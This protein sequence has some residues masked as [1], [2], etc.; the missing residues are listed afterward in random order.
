MRSAKD[1]RA[2]GHEVHAA[3]DDELRF[4]A[5]RGGARELQRVADVV[6]ELDDLIALVM[7]PK[8]HDTIAERLL[9]GR[10]AGVHLVVGKAQVFLGER[11]TLA[12][13]RL[14]D[15]GEKLDVQVASFQLPVSSREF[16]ATTSASAA[17]TPAANR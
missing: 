1:V 8:D 9:G 17:R 14:F 10:N 16:P 13:A 6:G 4:A 15:V 3:E 11:L 12:D 7:M 5:A 2:L